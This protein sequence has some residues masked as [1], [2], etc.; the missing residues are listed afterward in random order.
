MKL[1]EIKD[2]VD[3]GKTVNWKIGSYEVISGK[4]GW[5]VKCMPLNI[6]GFSLTD[7]HDLLRGKESDY[8]I[9]K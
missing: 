6:I 2:A 9:K 7:E 3:A 1:Q 4:A 8:F 5:F